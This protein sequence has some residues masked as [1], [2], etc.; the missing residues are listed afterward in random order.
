MFLVGR[1]TLWMPIR[2]SNLHRWIAQKYLCKKN[3]IR[4]MY[5]NLWGRRSRTIVAD[6]QQLDS[7]WHH[8]KK[9]RSQSFQQKLNFKSNPMRYK[10]WICL[11]L[12][13]WRHN[14]NCCSFSFT[15]KNLSDILWRQCFSK[16]GCCSC[17]KQFIPQTTRI[18]MI[19]KMLHG[20][21]IFTNIWTKKSPKCR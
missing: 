14:A 9:W 19:S 11:L 15:L 8:L 10:L 13:F 2:F 16:R 5:R 12:F 1:L 17:S 21:G 18:P 7:T 6:T 3:A 4:Y 20:A